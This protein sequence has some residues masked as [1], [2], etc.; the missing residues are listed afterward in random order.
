MRHQATGI[1]LQLILV[2]SDFGC[3]MRLVLD[4]ESRGMVVSLNPY[5]KPVA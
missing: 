2:G 1:R 4:A 3:G 5:L